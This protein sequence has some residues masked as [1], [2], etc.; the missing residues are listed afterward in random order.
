MAEINP[1]SEKTS[2]SEP[3]TISSAETPGPDGTNP[4]TH[5]RPGST[6]GT[7]D[8]NPSEPTVGT[9]GWG[10]GENEESTT[11]RSQGQLGRNERDEQP[12]G[13][14][15]FRCADAGNADC[16]FEASAASHN[17]LMTAIEKHGREAHGEIDEVTRRRYQ[18]AIRQRHA[19]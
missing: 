5:E 17:E 18:D 9:E 11:G 2:P 15:T 12:A 3:G 8:V 14:R 19:P 4:F 6:G 1:K 7:G 16:R 13:E 10:L